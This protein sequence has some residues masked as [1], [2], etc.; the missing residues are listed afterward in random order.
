[1]T[2]DITISPKG[3]P[4]CNCLMGN[5]IGTYNSCMHLCKYCYANFNK[6]L[7]QDNFKKHNPNSPFLIGEAMKEDKVSEAKQK[8]WKIRSE[9]QI[10]LF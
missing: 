7:V 5:D 9:A 2:K 6:T 1:M 3:K 8:S 4:I 10:A